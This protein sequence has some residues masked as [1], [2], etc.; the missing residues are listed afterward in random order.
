MA[1]LIVVSNR[2]A[3]PDQSVPAGGL[4]TGV[5]AALSGPDGGVWF[6]WSGKTHESPAVEPKEQ[7]KDGI[8]FVTIDLPT[9]NFDAYYDGF[10]NGSLWPL[11]HYFPG[12]FRYDPADFDA[13]MT[14]NRQF[15][16]ALVKFVEE[17]EAVWIHEYLF[18]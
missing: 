2:V 4:A 16:D 5:L 10:C 13:Y 18:R 6:G 17:G 14:V 11:H 9:T 3:V 15:A 8:R 12:A 7:E 1:R